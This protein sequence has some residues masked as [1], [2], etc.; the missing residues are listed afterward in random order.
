MPMNAAF[1]AATVPLLDIVDLKWLL[2][3]EGIRLHVERLQLDRAYADTLLAHAEQSD[4][5]ALRDAARRMRE[6]LANCGSA[7]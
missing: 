1:P 4:N 5:E 7:R 2:A 6:L 3:R